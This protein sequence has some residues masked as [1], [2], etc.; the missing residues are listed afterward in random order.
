MSTPSARPNVQ[1]VHVLHRDRGRGQRDAGAVDAFVLAEHA[2]FQHRRLDFCAVR[3]T[4]RA[5]RSS[6]PRAAADRRAARICARPANDVEMRPG[7]P[8]KSPVTMRSVSPPLSVSGLPPSRSP[9]RILGPPR[10]WRTATSR[11]ARSAA[12]RILRVGGGVRIVC[13]VRKIQA[14]YV[15][16]GGHQGIEHGVGVAGGPHGR[17]DLRA[18]HIES[19]IIGTA[20]EV[21]VIPTENALPASVSNQSENI[22]C[23]NCC[24]AS[25]RI[26][27]R[28]VFGENA[29]V[30]PLR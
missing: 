2:A 1:I 15:R 8:G 18:T 5:A 6:R 25:A 12:A 10:S 19:S 21:P 27:A 17:D 30:S 20:P 11:P 14:E 23:N 16:A 9:V 29:P 24:T 26:R 22:L 4:P 13:A 3:A 7:P 28:V